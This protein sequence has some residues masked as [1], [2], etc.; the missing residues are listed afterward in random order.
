MGVNPVLSV[1][2]SSRQSWP[3]LVA[4]RY[5]RLLAL[6]MYFTYCQMWIPLVARAFYDDFVTHRPMKW[7]KTE[8]LTSATAPAWRMRAP[9]AILVVFGNETGSH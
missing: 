8:G 9:Q 5:A 1:S 4:L 7:V 6:A 3:S 2:F